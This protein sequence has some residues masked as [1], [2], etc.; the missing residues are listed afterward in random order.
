LANKY[1]GNKI[2]IRPNID[3]AIFMHDRTNGDYV[4]IISIKN[5]KKL[6]VLK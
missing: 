5:C 6:L 1:S 2:Q 3:D 4:K